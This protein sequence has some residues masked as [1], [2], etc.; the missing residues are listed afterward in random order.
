MTLD[1][2]KE[3]AQCKAD[4]LASEAR[5]RNI[6]EKNADSVVVLDWEGIVLYMNSA[7]EK[8]FGCKME[9]CLGTLLG[10]P[11]V[12]DERTEV[13]IPQRNHQVIVAEMRVTET[14]WN[15]RPARLATLR[16]VTDRKRAEDALRDADRKKNEFLAMLAHELRNPLAPIKNAAQVF[17]LLGP[18]DPNLCYAR[19]VIDRQ[20]LHLSRLVDDLLDIS[21]ITRGKVHL[22]RQKIDLATVIFQAVE[23]S[24]PIM[25]SRRHEFKTIVPTE[26]I[27][28]WGDMTRLAQVVSN[29]LTNAAKYTPEGGLIELKAG[30]EGDLLIIE[31]SDSGLG[32]P[33]EML[34][35]VFDLF[36]QVSRSLDRSDGGLGIGLTLVKRLVEMH[37]GSVA[38]ESEGLGQGSRFIVKLPLSDDGRDD[39]RPLSRGNSNSSSSSRRILIVDED[40][41]SLNSLAILLRLNGHKTFTAQDAPAALEAAAEFEPQVIIIDV[42]LLKLEGLELVPRLR[43]ANEEVQPLLIAL[44]GYDR[45]EDREILEQAHFDHDLVKPPDIS[46]LSKMFLAGQVRSPKL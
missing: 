20:V 19:E 31:V 15:G 30:R 39:G 28:L 11:I 38:A 26:T 43:A 29:L 3:L 23:T 24:Q 16:D 34:G 7:A 32:I 5:F 18:N 12:P 40:L 36:T 33:P 21:R 25:S 44:T 8:M 42:E 27:L 10:I 9:D 13:D 22:Q 41:D 6:I 37:G 45:N 4:L 2:D 35:Q 14:E 46:A 1:R 17:R